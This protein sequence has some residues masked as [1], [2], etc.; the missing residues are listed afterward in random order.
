M[1]ERC[2]RSIDVIVVYVMEDS[3]RCGLERYVREASATEREMTEVTA[4][5]V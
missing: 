5:K 2:A 4:R 1:V 3:R